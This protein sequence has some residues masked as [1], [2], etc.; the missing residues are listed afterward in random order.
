MYTAL[1]ALQP[2]KIGL[3]IR[4]GDWQLTDSYLFKPQTLPW[5]FDHW[6]ECAQVREGR[7]GAA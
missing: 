3:Q 4:V 2:L 5:L 6:F 1:P 7:D